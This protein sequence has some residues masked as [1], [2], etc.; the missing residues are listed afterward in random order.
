MQQAEYPVS[1]KIIPRTRIGAPVPAPIEV[2]L[3]L[4]TIR[5]LFAMKQEDAAKTLR[6]SVT[7]LK[8]ACRQLGILRWPYTRGPS[9]SSAREKSQPS[10]T[11]SVGSD[12]T[13]DMDLSAGEN[14][15]SDDQ[16]RSNQ[17]G[18]S[19][20]HREMSGSSPDSLLEGIEGSRS[21]DVDRRWIEWYTTR[22]ES[23]VEIE[24]TRC[25]D[26][27]ACA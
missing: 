5:P 9:A 2:N 15:H 10:A 22:D 6:I 11:R 24:Q 18:S 7:S 23:D 3:D 1:V 4:D 26:I 17:S 14:E 13:A 21:T 27:E 16:E 12:S 20:F 8:A 19:S 25:S